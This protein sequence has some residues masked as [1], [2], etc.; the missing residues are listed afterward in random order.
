M[1]AL[2]MEVLANDC[3]YI[4]LLNEGVCALH[5]LLKSN[6]DSDLE[7][8]KGIGYKER[9]PAGFRVPKFNAP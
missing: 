8:I 6:L 5:N 7:H 4:V 1:S 9:G 2:P 3:V